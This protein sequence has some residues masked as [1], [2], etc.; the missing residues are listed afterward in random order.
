MKYT[1]ATILVETKE[2]LK[3]VQKT[4]LSLYPNT[5]ERHPFSH[6]SDIL[7]VVVYIGTGDHSNNS[8]NNDKLGW[9]SKSEYSGGVITIKDF[10]IIN[11]IP[12]SA[13]H[14]RLKGSLAGVVGFMDNYPDK[15]IEVSQDGAFLV[16]DITDKKYHIF[17]L[18]EAEV[19]IKSIDLLQDSLYN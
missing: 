7:P 9:D 17:T 14:P 12:N 5:R 10:N 15:H 8:Y 6:L 19:I 2:D 1:P 18:D 11:D 16:D 4:L 13:T 3:E